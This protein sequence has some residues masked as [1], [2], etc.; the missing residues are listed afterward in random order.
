MIDLIYHETILRIY[1]IIWIYPCTFCHVFL[2]QEG[3]PG[4]E[5]MPQEAQIVLLLWPTGTHWHCLPHASH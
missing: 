4:R 3:Y 5:R 1:T 2:I